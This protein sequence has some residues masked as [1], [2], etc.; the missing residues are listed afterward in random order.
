MKLDREDDAPEQSPGRAP[1]SRG[2][3]YVIGSE[4]LT[5]ML[6]VREMHS[7]HGA[8]HECAEHQQ[9]YIISPG[10]EP[11]VAVERVMDQPEAG[12]KEVKRPQEGEDPRAALGSEERH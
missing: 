2:A 4:A 12:E 8:Q 1:A 3:L 6:Q 11:E 9:D 5:V 10:T 7:V